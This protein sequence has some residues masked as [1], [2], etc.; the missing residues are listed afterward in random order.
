MKIF[1][2]GATGVIGRALVP[3][4][5]KSGHTITAITRTPGHAAALQAM[6]VAPVICDVFDRQKLQSVLV[7]ASPDAVIHQLTA[8]PDR[9]DP[10]KIQQ[11]LAPTNRLRTEGTQI[12]MDAAKAAGVRK[13]IAQSVSFYY[14][15]T[16]AQPATECDP[17][18]IDAPAAF[19]DAVQA[20]SELERITL[21]TASVDGIVLRYGYLYGSGTVY[22]PDGTFTAD[23]RNRKIPIIGNGN[24]IFSFIHVED[25]AAATVLAL[26]QGKPGIYNIVDDNPTPLH[27]WLPIY[28]KLAKAQVPRHIP[29]WL[30]RV[31]AGPFAIYYMTKQRGASNQKAKKELGWQPAYPDWREGFEAVL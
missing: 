29:K 4:L 20:L 31:A 21:E 27:E 26:H 14:A 28:A 8:L 25:A 12:L 11:V 3:M 13:F 10:R 18:Y 22:A 9:I 19:V 1:I 30:G 23:V 6:G 24:G 17:L 5:Q 15:P 2:A 16:S 7:D